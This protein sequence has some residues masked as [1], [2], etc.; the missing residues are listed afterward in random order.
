VEAISAGPFVEAF[1]FPRRWLQPFGQLGLPLEVRWQ[2]ATAGFAVAAYAGTG[3]RFWVSDRWSL[4][5][6][7]R[8][9]VVASNGFVVW[10]EDLPPGS[11][12]FAAGLEVAAHL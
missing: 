4:G 1:W 7:V 3:V 11:V 9:M 6:A 2:G 10:N 5:A 12:S 8:L